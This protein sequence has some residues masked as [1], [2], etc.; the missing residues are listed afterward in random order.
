MLETFIYT[1]DGKCISS[2]CLTSVPSWPSSAVILRSK[3]ADLGFLIFLH[4]IEPTS[5]VTILVFCKNVTNFY[6]HITNFTTTSKYM[7]CG[8]S[9]FIRH[10][11][12]WIYLEIILLIHYFVESS[13]FI[14]WNQS[15]LHVP[16]EILQNFKNEYHYS[17]TNKPFCWGGWDTLWIFLINVWLFAEEKWELKTLNSLLHSKNQ[18]LTLTNVFI[19]TH[20][21]LMRVCT[22]WCW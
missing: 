22:K 7:Y 6:R 11:I 15:E 10:L 21:L 14:W 8:S 5:W 19:S 16:N 2:C 4:E 9:I 1:K 12:S 18:D 17:S 3:V 20:H 13:L